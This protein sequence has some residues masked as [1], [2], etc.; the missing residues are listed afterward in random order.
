MLPVAPGANV[1][2]EKERLVP[3][4]VLMQPVP[5]TVPGG[6]QVIVVAVTV[7]PPPEQLATF[8]GPIAAAKALEENPKIHTPA[9]SQI[10]LL[11]FFIR[12]PKLSIGNRSL[13]ALCAFPSAEWPGRTLVISFHAGPLRSLR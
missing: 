6:S 8:N 5:L 1:P 11:I 4:P 7:T 12:S 13:N 2:P 3:I 9:K 10:L